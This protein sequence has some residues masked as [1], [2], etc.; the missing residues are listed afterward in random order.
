M[1]DYP[2]PAVAVT[3]EVSLTTA[4]RAKPFVGDGAKNSELK[5]EPP[6]H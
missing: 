2:M 4:K 1:T 5:E 3:E 6:R